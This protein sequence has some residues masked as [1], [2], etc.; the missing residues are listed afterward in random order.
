MAA[1]FIWKHYFIHS[2]LFQSFMICRILQINPASAVEVYSSPNGSPRC[3]PP[4][5]TIGFYVH[6]THDQSYFQQFAVL[7]GILFLKSAWMSRRQHDSDTSLLNQLIMKVPCASD[8]QN[9][10]IF[11]GSSVVWIVFIFSNPHPTPPGSCYR[12][13]LTF[14]N[15]VWYIS[16]WDQT[17]NLQI[18][19]VCL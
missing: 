19:L 1:N 11:Q 6:N 2:L 17:V 9:I 10:S 18:S 5:W 15:C 4:C 16:S 12:F 13:L 8:L 7:K 3:S 14:W